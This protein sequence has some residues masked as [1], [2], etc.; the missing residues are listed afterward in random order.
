MSETRAKYLV[1][2]NYVDLTK[3]KDR[4]SIDCR[5]GLWAIDAPTEEEA[6]NEAYHYWQQYYSDGEYK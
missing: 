2:R 4:V 3:T 6:I 1:M 5:K